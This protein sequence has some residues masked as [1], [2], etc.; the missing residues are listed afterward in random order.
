MG[1][2][3]IV[4]EIL[5]SGSPAAHVPSSVCIIFTLCIGYDLMRYLGNDVG[6]SGESTR[7][8]CTNLDLWITGSC[9][10]WFAFLHSQMVPSNAAQHRVEVLLDL[11]QGLLAAR[12]FI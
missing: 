5:L 11:L 2:L 8:R 6:N 9:I 4:T 12:Q 3:E 10:A 7:T 1:S